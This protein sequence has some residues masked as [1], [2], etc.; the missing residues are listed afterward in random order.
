MG[1]HADDALNAAYDDEHRHRNDMF[2]PRPYD[3]RFAT[4]QDATIN[5][6][7]Q[8]TRLRQRLKSKGVTTND[9]RIRPRLD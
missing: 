6:E 9:L 4:K 3:A 5:A 8:L 1:D 7:H 2:H